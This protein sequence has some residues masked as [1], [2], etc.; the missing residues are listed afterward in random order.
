MQHSDKTRSLVQGGILPG[1]PGDRIRARFA[2]SP[3]NEIG[4][5]KFLSAESSAALAANAFGLFL[6]RPELLP[7]LPVGDDI[8]WSPSGVEIEVENRF[9]WSGGRHPWLDAMVEMPA[10]LVAIESK[11]Y[12]PFRKR[13]K[14]SLSDAYWRPVWGGRMTG[15]CSMRDDLRAG[16]LVFRH[17]DAGQ[18][19]TPAFGLRTAVHR[20]GRSQGKVPVLVYLYAEPVAWP[21]GREISPDD[22]SRHRDEIDRFAD[23]IAGDEV[24][25]VALSYR[26]LLEAW[27]TSPE[28]AVRDHADAV[29]AAFAPL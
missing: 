24:R 14:V 1:L 10:A 6:D 21:G 5:G 25:F 18:L 19:L 17:L 13:G 27:R 7:P 16:T 3:G 11:R 28:A 9:P 22:M 20:V 4:S 29:E 2:A 26:A 23:R 15:C 8:A 12:E